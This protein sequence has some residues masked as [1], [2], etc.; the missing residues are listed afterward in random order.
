MNGIWIPHSDDQFFYWDWSI[1]NGVP[2]T[3]SHNA[4]GAALINGFSPASAELHRIVNTLK[5]QQ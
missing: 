5:E 1:R 2:M 4:S 3:L